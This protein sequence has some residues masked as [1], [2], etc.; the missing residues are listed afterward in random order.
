MSDFDQGLGGIYDFLH[1]RQCQWKSI[2]IGEQKEGA[3]RNE[4]KNRETGQKLR[5]SQHQC[6]SWFGCYSNFGLNPIEPNHRCFPVR[7]FSGRGDNASLA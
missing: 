2:T 1:Q 7:L 3:N 5:R 4:P 6:Q